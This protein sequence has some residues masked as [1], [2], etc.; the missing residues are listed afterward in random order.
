MTPVTYTPP[1]PPHA[2][3]P[4][5]TRRI[6]MQKV[7]IVLALLAGNV[8]AA[9]AYTEEEHLNLEVVVEGGRR[10]L[11]PLLPGTKCPKGHIC[12]ARNVR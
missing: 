6:M 5:R 1:S 11:F 2:R 10:E 4:A 7:L 9:P 8:A 12:R 3:A